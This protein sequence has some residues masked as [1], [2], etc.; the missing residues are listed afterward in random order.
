MDKLQTLLKFGTVASQHLNAKA[1]PIMNIVA[2]HI[3]CKHI[4]GESMLAS[5]KGVQAYPMGGTNSAKSCYELGAPGMPSLKK[6]CLKN[7][8]VK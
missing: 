2:S 5:L 8:M 6:T 1:T 4:A 3:M 7:G